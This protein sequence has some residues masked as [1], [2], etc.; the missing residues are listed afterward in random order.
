M[1]IG[2]KTLLWGYHQV[3]LHPLMVAFAWWKLY[4]LPFDPRLWFAFFVHDIG[5]FGKP[6]MDGPE[7]SKHPY[8]GARIMRFLFGT[9]WFDFC[10]NHSR[11]I[12]K[13]SGA[14]V[15]DLCYAD[16]LAF[17]LYPKWLLKL[18][19]KLS[20]E[21]EHY[22]ADRGVSDWDEWYKWAV[23]TNEITLKAVQKV[24]SK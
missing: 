1:K 12:A 3:F 15:S 5:Y 20:G 8:T 24:N 14:P 4:G 10:A 6:N 13:I 18:L 16:K 21:Y 2:T 9:K 19:Y 11:T 17:M 23:G 22:M 7:G